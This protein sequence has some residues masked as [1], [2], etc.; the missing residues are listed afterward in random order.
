MRGPL[1]RLFGAGAIVV[2][3]LGG[4][5]AARMAGWIPDAV[6]YWL[7]PALIAALFLGFA[8]YALIAGHRRLLLP[9]GTGF[10]VQS[11]GLLMLAMRKFESEWEPLWYTLG[12]VAAVLLVMGIVWLVYRIRARLLE[13]RLTDGLAGR[14]GEDLARIRKDMLDA[15]GLLKR[16][17][18]GRNAIYE[19]PWF[20]VTGRPAAG[21]TVAIKNSGLG[22]PVKKDWVKGVGGTYTC[23]WFFTNDMIF[24]D[25]PGKWVTE[26]AD[27][28]GQQYW[29]QLLRLLRKYHGRRPLDGLVVAVPADDLLSKDDEALREHAANAREVVDL[30]HAELRFRLPVYLLVTK[31]DL[32]EG[33]V[34]FF[35]GLPAKRRHEILGWSNEEPSR[36]DVPGLIESGFTT[37]Q[38]RLETYRLEMLGR[39]ASRSQARRLFF[40]PEEFRGLSGPL[41]VFGDE[42]FRK[43]RFHDTPVFRGFY[44][45]SGTQG[46]GEPLSRAMAELS[47]T[48]G[49]SASRPRDKAQEEPKRSYFLLDLFREL[50]V[51]DEGLVGRTTGHWWKQRRNTTLGA[52]APAAVA[53]LILLLA[54][55]SLLLNRGLYGNLAETTPELVEQLESIPQ[56]LEEERVTEALEATGQLRTFHR[57]LA[58][59]SL[60]R[61][62]GMRR[63][64]ALA[65]QSLR[66][67]RQQ[68]SGAV[69]APTLRSAEEL[70]ISPDESCISR[71]DVLH[72]VVWLRMGR[73]AQFSDDLAGF[74]RVWGLSTEESTE[75]RRELLRQYGYYKDYVPAES[76]QGPVL[77]GFS[78]RKVA[79]SIE[80]NCSDAG[81]ASTLQMYRAFQDACGNAV[82]GAEVT[83]CYG[84]LNEV[85]RH[86]QEDYDRFVSHFA[87]LKRDLEELQIEEPEAKRGL[88]LLASIDLVES[89]TSECLTRF[90]KTVIP[91][92]EEYAVRDDLLEECRAEVA[93]LSDRGEQYRI[94]NEILAAQKE[95]LADQDEDLEQLMR[96]YTLACRGEVEGFR[97]LDFSTL[98]KIASSYRRV[99]CL[100]IEAP[101]PKATR[102]APRKARPKRKTY[103]WFVSPDEVSGQYRKAHWESKYQEWSAQLSHAEVGFDDDQKLHLQNTLRR[104]V[105]GYADRYTDAWLG[106]LGRVDLKPRGGSVAD[107]LE[108]LSSTPE[109]ATVL[110]AAAEAGG[111]ADDLSD[112]PYDVLQDRLRPL[113]TLGKF[114]DADLAEYQ[115]ML[116]RIAED[117]HNCQ[118]DSAFFRDYRRAVESA[119]RDNAL[120][121]ARNWV[122]SNA[123][124]NLADNA[125]Q[126]M[127]RKPLSEAETFVRSDN[128]LKSQWA[129]LVRIYDERIKEHAPFS[130]DLESE[131]VSVEDVTALFG[132]GTGALVRVREAA[133]GAELPQAAESWLREAELLSG[134]FFEE[135]NDEPR[136]ARLRITFLLPFTY[137]PEG[138]EKST[139]VQ[140]VRIYFGESAEF[141]WEEDEDTSK[142]LGIDLFGDDASEYSYL[143]GTMA[144]KKGLVA[145]TV[146]SDWKEGETLEASAVEGFWAPLRMIE[147]ALQGAELDPG[148]DEFELAYVLEIPLKKDRVARAE[149]PLKIS[150]EDVPALL[151]L[152]RSGLRPPPRELGG[153]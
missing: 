52:F 98:E 1:V 135:T 66:V 50:M 35:K 99:A 118:A 63:P 80:E 120:V 13:R 27:E 61:D 70:A 102:S 33:F 103:S 55:V 87:S 41:S 49:V 44:F 137:D 34:D 91:V 39:V 84:K 129:D 18:H 140:E 7:W 131:P 95:T 143:R 147:E 3:V 104:E 54:L 152:M 73:R 5:R 145:R 46:E 110:G 146:G 30:I 112:P 133:E 8:I 128:L 88:E 149:L 31:C 20:L 105:A 72:S 71:I 94:R 22:L 19:L 69:L 59:F 62:L 86:R 48:L 36:P 85:L 144:E 96:D 14:E 81:S 79:G 11:I 90:E 47:K 60:V 114:I 24:L 23:D 122:Q 126:A 15:L 123:G 29:K 67:F 42:F 58:G 43:D 107:W 16:A 113:S 64:G 17:G 21:K 38:R 141:R 119:D 65:D 83:E 108:Q 101:A 40:F 153:R 127:L 77:P 93:G 130:G 37:V 57:K 109:Y 45:S 121:Q 10:V 26:G 4:T 92:I 148:A 25:T 76:E 75:A 151:R 111:I 89:Q 97:R 150:G 74:D 136:K 56:P 6:A 138:F 115:G 53:G 51:A 125:L 9:L 100:G 124:P 106:Y 132:G 2:L 134:V 78:I 142:R 28:S 117:L 32:V 116:G 68:F 82:T 139:R 12:A